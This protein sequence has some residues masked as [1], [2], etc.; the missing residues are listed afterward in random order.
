MGALL[1]SHRWLCAAVAL[2]GSLAARPAAADPASDEPRLWLGGGPAVLVV[3][4]EGYENTVG[5][6]LHLGA[7]VPL[8]DQFQLVAGL[9]AGSF[10]LRRQAPNPCP[11]PPAPC[12]ATDFPYRVAS[13]TAG[14]GLRYVLDVTHVRPSFGA[15]LTGARLGAGDSWIQALAGQRAIEQHLGVT[16]LGNVDYRLTGRLSVGL[17]V[18]WFMSRSLDM[19]AVGAQA[20]WAAF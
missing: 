14:I 12:E 13:A 9:D 7:R 16:L 10:S 18:R 15:T 20:E 4:R 2:A 8:N 6:G 5:P 19:T 17:F 11:D 1:S 3:S